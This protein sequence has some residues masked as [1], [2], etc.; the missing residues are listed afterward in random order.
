MAYSIVGKISRNSNAYDHVIDS[1]VLNMNSSINPRQVLHKLSELLQHKNTKT[2][3]Q[4]GIKMEE[5]CALLTD[6]SSF[7]YKITYVCR[8]GKHNPKN[9]TH[10]PE[11]CWAE[12]PELRPNQKN[13]NGKRPS[14]PETHQTGLEAL[15]TDKE[16]MIDTPLSCVID[17]GATYH[18]FHHKNLFKNLTLN[19][20]ERIATSNPSSNLLCKG[21]GMV[22]IEVNNKLFKL[23]SCLYF[24]RLTRNLVSLLGLCSEPITITRNG[25]FF[26]LSKQNKVFLS[27]NII[28]K[29]MIVMFDQPSAILTDVP[30]KTPWN[31]SL[32]HPGNHVLKALVL[33]IHNM[34]PCDI[35]AQGKMTSL[36][37]KGNFTE[38][39]MPLD[40]IHMDIVVPI[41][42]LSKSGHC[43]FLTITDQHNSFKITKFLKNKSD[44]YDELIIQLKYMENIHEIKVK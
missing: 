25:S 17:C 16:I 22:E 32:C 42:P 18:I 43:Y 33:G 39:S 21:R 44:I 13:K 30:D 35:C 36:P 26:H 12:H 5:N 3:F 29:R 40:C 8:D 2:S 15:F 31:A 7:P 4:K 14:N 27:S 19:S 37:F 38:T 41:S 28:N 23:Q 9:T 34:D 1:M 6:S 10:K 24:L 20:N 11:N